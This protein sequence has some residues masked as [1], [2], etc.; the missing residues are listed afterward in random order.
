[1]TEIDRINEAFLYPSINNVLSKPPN[2]SFTKIS[3]SKGKINLCP[4]VGPSM[5]NDGR[6]GGGG[7]GGYSLMN[8]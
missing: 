5:K 6:R 1:M 8:E 2:F 4:G 7:G 3:V